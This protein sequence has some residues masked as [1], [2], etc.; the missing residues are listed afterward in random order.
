MD[1]SNI[2]IFRILFFRKKHILLISFISIVL[3]YIFTM[4][5]FVKPIYKSTAYIYPANLGLYSEES[6]TEQM[7]QFLQSNDIRQYLYKKYNLA[8]HYKIDTL[9]KTHM[10]AYD[11]VYDKKVGISITKYESVEIKVEDYSPDTAR[12]LVN[13]IIEAVNWLIEKEHREKYA[14]DV[15]NSK[16]YLDFKTRDIDSVQHVLDELSSKYGVV[17]M[18][19]QLK[20]A[21]RSYY[22]DMN[23]SAKLTELIANLGKYGVEFVKMSSYLESQ[24]REYALAVTEYQKHLSE[25]NY[26]KSF[27][28]MASKPTYPVVASWPKRTLVMTIAGASVFLLACIYFVFIDKAKIVYQQVT[29]KDINKS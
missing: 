8:K 23:G 25:L 3:G 16:I 19:I 29:S 27:V 24:I 17:D 28:A 4:S 11:E 2:E 22:K 14:D 13:G 12:L 18:R 20:E 26:K 15:K 6:Q 5:F 9:K 7:L 10:F 21:A 1:K